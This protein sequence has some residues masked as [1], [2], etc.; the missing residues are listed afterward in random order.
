MGKSLQN[1]T[2][3]IL[4]YAKDSTKLLID[5]MPKKRQELMDFIQSYADDGKSWKYT[6]VLKSTG[7]REYVKT[8]TAGN[9]DEIRIYTHSDYKI[10]SINQIASQEFG[11]DTKKAY[12]IYIDKVFRT[13]NAQTSIRT[14]V[15]DESK[16]ISS[17]LISID[18]VPTKGKNAGQVTTIYYKDAVRNMVAFLK[19]VVSV[20]HDDIYKLDN[21]GNLWDDINYNNLAN[22][23]GMSFPNGQKPIQLLERLL[24]MI[25]CKDG[26]V[27][28]FFSGSSST[29]HATMH[30]NSIDS[31]RRKFIM[32]QLPEPC[33]AKGDFAKLGLKN[34]CDV[35]KERIRKAGV[36]IKNNFPMTTASVDTGFR[37]FKLDDSNMKDVFYSPV[38]YDQD[39]L[40]MLESNIKEDRTDLDL[41]FGCLL[42][43]GLPL[44]MPYTSEEI[45][46]CTVHNYNDGDLIACFDRNI[47]D[48]VF[49]AIA[50]KQPLRAVFRDSSFADS[51]SK[52][53]VGETFKL[54][55]PDTRVKV[56]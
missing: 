34:I 12:Y 30:L 44:S 56:I 18:Y 16:D 24:Q 20:E 55:S 27:L 35:G 49:K 19:E 32:V 28:D 41:L 6:S 26:Y 1:N 47:P 14:R 31:G 48:S 5:T 50:K 37:V 38:E 17:E 11:G 53:N 54:L 52:I 8:I 3:Y 43:W 42:E 9:G 39:L 2:E 33:D 23:A 45:S 25:D 13:T 7:I 29:A 21:A 4:F 40:S 15:M 51:P 22:E 36:K 10:Q 46:G